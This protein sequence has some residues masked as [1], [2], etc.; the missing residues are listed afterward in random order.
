MLQCELC[1]AVH[2][3]RGGGALGPFLTCGQLQWLKASPFIPCGSVLNHIYDVPQRSQG[4]EY[5]LPTVVADLIK[6]FSNQASP[7]SVHSAVSSY[8]LPGIIF[9]TNK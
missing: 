8:V 6:H 7:S 3:G 5:R 9:K 1:P 2:A 4:M